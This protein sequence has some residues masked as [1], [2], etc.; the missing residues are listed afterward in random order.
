M[1][2]IT[3]GIFKG[4]RTLSIMPTFQCNAQCTNCG[5]L[6]GPSNLTSLK[7]NTI[8]SA[9]NEAVQLGFGNVVFTGGEATLR[10]N[11]LLAGIQHAKSLGLV[12]RL[13]TNGNWAKTIEIAEKKI[14]SL[15]SAGLDEI[16]FSTGDEHIR[17]IPLS[18]I[19]NCIIASNSNGLR[20]HLMIENK[21]KR[22]VT[23]ERLIDY[24]ENNF[25]ENTFSVSES[26]WMPLDPE[27]IEQYSEGTTINS[28][29]ITAC[30]GCDSIL[31]SITLQAN[32][33]VS[34]CCGIGMRSIPELV[35]ANAE[36]DHF[37]QQGIE[38]SENDLF[39][40]WLH[41][42]G[43]E[44][45]LAWAAEKDPSI[46]W[47]GIYSHRCQACLRIYKDPK[48]GAIIKSHYYDKIGDILSSAWMDEVFIPQALS[49]GN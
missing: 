24:F 15:R 49:K 25:K 26:P 39:K 5:T 18:Y 33:D 10:W 19:A 48:I 9:I 37:L 43:P 23:K 29:N 21:E 44:K 2:E 34:A 20:P 11:D 40:L 42:E 8:L 14:N 27:C 22:T 30:V 13:V 12:T 4:I 7:L 46:L 3:P 36:D 1:N 41:Y 16:N 32:G 28:R 38:N 35:V 17:F 47:E 45:I 6:S 31:Q